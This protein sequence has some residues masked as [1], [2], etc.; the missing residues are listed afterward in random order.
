MSGSAVGLVY[1]LDI[2]LAAAWRQECGG[3]VEAGV[4]LGIG[5][6]SVSLY[7]LFLT[8]GNALLALAESVV[9]RTERLSRANRGLTI[10]PHTYDLGGHTLRGGTVKRV[11]PPRGGRKREICTLDFK[12][13][14]W[15]VAV[16]HRLPCLDCIITA[17]E[18][19]LSRSTAS[20]GD[21]DRRVSIPCSTHAGNGHCHSVSPQELA[22]PLLLEDPFPQIL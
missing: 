7:M 17:V 4:P 16:F 19:C 13:L 6:N 3:R 18:L 1:V 8:A 2:L 10:S 20:M 15:E 21:D 5:K 9:G 14:S 11:L 22:E 12:C